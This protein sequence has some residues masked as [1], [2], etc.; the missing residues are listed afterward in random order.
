MEV[1][2][3]RLIRAAELNGELDDDDSGTVA[4]RAP[5]TSGAP[6]DAPPGVSPTT[7]PRCPPH[8]RRVAAEI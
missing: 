3:A 2:E 5:K 8:R 1:M 4:Q 7:A 6:R